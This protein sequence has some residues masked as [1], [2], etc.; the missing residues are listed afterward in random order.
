M[1]YVATGWV[2]PRLLAKPLKQLAR[3]NKGSQIQTS[4]KAKLTA[5][6]QRNKDSYLFLYT[7]LESTYLVR[8]MKSDYT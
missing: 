4:S 3:I 6:T 5:L 1:W 2:K 7:R 8:H